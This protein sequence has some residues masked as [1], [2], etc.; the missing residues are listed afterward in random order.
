[1]P[2]CYFSVVLDG[3][4]IQLTGEQE[5]LTKMI[6]S[7]RKKMDGDAEH[8]YALSATTGCAFP[9]PLLGP[10]KKFDPFSS[11]GSSFDYVSTF[12]NCSN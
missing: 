2:C 11:A 5:G 1:M 7:L 12:A 8:K 10:K 6:N 3:I 9:D 4:D